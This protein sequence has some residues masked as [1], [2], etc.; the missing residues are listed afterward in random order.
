MNILLLAWN[1]P[2]TLGG[3]EY[4]AKHLHEGLLAAGH[5]VRVVA[6][7]VE[8]VAS[9]PDVA[10]CP[11][12]GLPA[13]LCYSFIKGYTLGRRLRPDVIVCPS[14]VTAP[15]AY[16]LSHLLRRPYVVLVHGSDILRRGRLYQPAVRF[17]LRKATRLAANS[18]YTKGLLQEAGCNPGLVH[19]I[20]PGVSCGAFEAPGSA[21]SSPFVSRF[22]GRRVLLSVAR[23]IRRKGILEFVTHVM[24]QLVRT[25]PDVLFLVV[26]DD[27]T[28]SLAHKERMRAKIERRVRDLGLEN[29][30]FLMGCLP[31]TELMHHYRRAEVFVLPCLD[32]PDDVEGFGIVFLEAA[33]AGAPSVA[34]RV[35]GIPEAIVNGQT[36][37]LT[38]PGDFPGLEKAISTLLRDESSRRRFAERGARRARDLFD[39]PLVISEYV[40]L[41]EQS[42]KSGVT[43]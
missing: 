26:G 8:G 2:P 1:F 17:L 12:P 22:E 33:L 11:R 21:H 34:T 14:V 39:W 7:F 42:R 9:G 28:R 32:M 40:T 30:V 31:D 27:A 4:V 15:A 38:E 23:L 19:V 35:G 41:F 10:R 18:H 29:H 5:G 25:F 13:F 24:P 20:H 43:S 3:I 6:P 37:V 16:L 36:G